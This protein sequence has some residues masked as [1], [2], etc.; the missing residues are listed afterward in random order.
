MDNLEKEYETLDKSIDKSD[1]R[2]DETINYLTANET[3]PVLK[4]CPFC[5]REPECVQN[6]EYTKLH[7]GGYAWVVRCNYM[8][9]GCGA[10]GGCRQDK[11]E[12]IE[13]W[14]NR[15]KENNTNA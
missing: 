7:D 5:G 12:A 1:F 13:A 3:T 8:K 14:N 9:G 4:P 2:I 15:Q 6:Y 11:D 10:S